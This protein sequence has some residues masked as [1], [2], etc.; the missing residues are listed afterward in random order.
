M[1]RNVFVSVTASSYFLRSQMPPL[2]LHAVG[3]AQS[4]D[5][6]VGAVFRRLLRDPLSTL[7]GRWNWKSALL[8]SLLRSAIFFFANLSAG[9]P[10]ALAA[11]QTELFFRAISS[12]F[13]GAL[14]ESFCE[15]E[16]PWAATLA[17]A[18]FL[19]FANHSLEFLIHWMR[20]TRRL[21]PSILF[22]VC[23]TLV[24]TLF[25]FYAMR[26]GALVVGEGRRSL[27]QD[28]RAMPRLLVDFI[29]VVPRGIRRAAESATRFPGR[30]G[31]SSA[32]PKD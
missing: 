23:F 8:S 28:L 2:A 12:G 25:N 1:H 16:P 7:C 17:V 29:L 13:Y 27:A 31:A 19:P 18:V 24:S 5:R 6:S 4:T 9:L 32:C 30:S 10:A 15:A 22:S 20:G 21:V 11:M 26:R 3:P 14:T